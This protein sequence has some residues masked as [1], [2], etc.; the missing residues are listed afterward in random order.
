MIVRRRGNRFI[1]IKQHDH[2]LISGEFAARLNQKIEPRA[3][4]LYAI[5]HHDVG[6]IE[7]DQTILWNEQTNEP[8]SFNDYPLL[9]KL[10]A[11][12]QGISR[13]EAHDPYAGFL[14]SKHFAS[15]FTN[16][17][18]PAAR[19]FHEQE[20]AR[21]DQL[22]KHFS[23]AEE[24]NSAD[25]FRL[26][27]FCDDL[28]LSLCLNEPQQNTHPWYADGIDYHGRKVKW[29]WEDEQ[30]LRLVPNLFSTSFTF[31]IPYQVADS[32]RRLVSRNVFRCR[33]LA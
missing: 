1:L 29:V 13:V 21:Q 24:Q 17:S 33:V 11:Y 25:N 22:K 28:S 6:W 31:E 19:R 3:K 7:L 23:E 15:F 20:L 32:S 12:T 30:S 27:Q 4:T 16:V 14:C 18:D 26:L 8:Y 5:S 9:P 2:A 10:E